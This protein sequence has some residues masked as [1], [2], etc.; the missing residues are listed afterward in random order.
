MRTVAHTLALVLVLVAEPA[1]A[2]DAAE[3]WAFQ[4][5]VAPAIP[6]V[7]DSESVCNPIDAFVAAEREQRGLVAAP[8]ADKASL[9]RRVY[10]DLI[11]LPPT[12]DELH[13][14]LSDSSPDAY[15]KVVNRLLAS[16]QY[17]ERWG[18]HWMD[19]WRYSDW[20]GFMQEVRDSQPHIWRWRDWIVESLNADKGYDRMVMEMLAGD[21]LS[22]DDP[23]TLRAT[24]FLARSW[25]KFNRN[26]W[27]EN[28]VEH[29]CKAFLALTVNC[30]KCHDHK[31][32]PISQKE[33]F[34]LRAFFEPQEVRTDRVPGQADVSKD[35]LVRIYDGHATDPTYLFVR[36]DE[37]E[38]AKEEPLAPA[39]PA[40]FATR[41]AIAPVSLSAAARYP[42]L[43]P[44][45]QQEAAAASQSAVERAR[46]EVAS[47]L[48][49]TPEQ[50]WVAKLKLWAA[51]AE[52]QFV[53]A[54][55]AADQATYRTPAAAEAQELIRTAANAERR[56]K[57]A[58]AEAAAAEAPLALHVKAPA[59]DA[60]KTLAD[61]E[62]ALVEART[63]AQEPATSY[64][65]LGPVYPATSTGRRLALA[66]WIVSR[67]NPLAARVAVNDIWM[68][69]FGEPLV[70]TVFDF[71]RNGHPPTHPQLLDWLAVQFMNDGWSMK[72]IHRLMVTSRTY[73]MA[74][75]AGDAEESNRRTDPDNQYLWR[76]NAKRMEAET[77]RDSVLA[78]CGQLDS[79]MG[80]PDIDQDAG[81]A[82]H[83]RSIY[84]RHAYEK[85]MIFL[86][87]F[88]APSPGECYRRM[89]TVMPQQALAMS[90]SGLALS[91]AR[92]LA[93][94]L[95]SESKADDAF[96][97]SAFEQVLARP[98]TDAERDAC[99]RFLHEQ[100]HRLAEPAKLKAF[101]SGD[102]AAIKPAAD[103][104]QRA[105]E[106]LVHVLLNHN[107]FVTIH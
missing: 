55:I 2:G 68:R 67:D 13:A 82:I 41:I 11:G 97:A 39:V 54:R 72:K 51:K 7:K 14:F 98:P 45:E 43:R 28:T 99:A 73:R 75:F 44:F 12:R 102:P 105:R 71:G 25:Y 89:P 26:V 35:G 103:P 84:F 74:S 18:R 76:A 70:S 20:A 40:I 69:H 100:S 77:V 104:K 80:G 90:N 1:R 94:R 36:G 9:L 32:D 52:H 38:P 10:L 91:A 60:A 3:H 87:T 49:G 57:L 4:S 81:F 22:P 34:A 79:T 65:P 24:G 58:R 16:P 31:Y 37:K 6:Q 29:T 27:L 93:A 59:A 107:D 66:R 61:A 64:T 19:V 50:V 86:T 8:Q 63:V 21:E 88:D 30:A 83:R 42:G 5:P 23:H 53:I 95:S 33:H 46:Q 96:I 17:G 47:A 101:D 78:V 92:T 62:K 56:W 85:Q 48:K 15:E 106:N